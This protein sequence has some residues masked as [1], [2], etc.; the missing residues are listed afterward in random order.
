[1]LEKLGDIPVMPP[2]LALSLTFFMVPKVF[3]P[4]KFNCIYYWIDR[5][6]IF[7]AG[8]PNRDSNMRPSAP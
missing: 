8:W 6:R 1:M 7:V 2:I 5:E 4:L 3:E